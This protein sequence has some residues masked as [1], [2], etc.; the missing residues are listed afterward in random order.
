MRLTFKEQTQLLSLTPSVAHA[1]DS[2]SE[3][4]EFKNLYPILTP[5]DFIS[6][7]NASHR[8]TILLSSMGSFW[9][10]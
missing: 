7:S 2:D 1:P 10:T 5:A 6:S 3:G 9:A 4:L 8:R